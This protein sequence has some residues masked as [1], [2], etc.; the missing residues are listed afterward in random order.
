M[1]TGG[2]LPLRE[3][4]KQQPVAEAVTMPSMADLLPGRR[5]SLLTLSLIT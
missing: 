2:H 5:T 1:R 4:R 3:Q